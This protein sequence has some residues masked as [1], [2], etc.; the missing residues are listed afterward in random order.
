MNF[1][2]HHLV[3]LPGD[4]NDNGNYVLELANYY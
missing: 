2:L 4:W 3:T 1:E